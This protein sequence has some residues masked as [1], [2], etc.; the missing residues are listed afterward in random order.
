M[1]TRLSSEDVEA[2]FI[3]NQYP[4]FFQD[5]QAEISERRHTSSLFFDKGEYS[6]IYFKGVHIGYGHFALRQRTLIQF[7]TDFETIEMHFSLSGKTTVRTVNENRLFEFGDNQHNIIYVSPF[8]GQAEWAASSAMQIFEVNLLPEF[9]APYMPGGSQRFLDFERKIRHHEPSYLSPCNGRITPQMRWI[10]HEIIH[11]NRT[12][13]FKKMFIESKVI[14]LLLLQLE[15]INDAKRENCHKLKKSDVDK[16]HAVKDLLMGN[17]DCTSS[18]VQLAHQ[19]GTNE[20]TLKKGFK[21]V[22]GTTVFGFWNEMK[23]EHAKKLLLE[24]GLAISDVSE[25]VGYK[26]PQHF[27]AA[28]KR[29]FGVAPKQLKQ[30]T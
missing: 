21:E 23:M 10:I 2:L 26:N 14:E 16:M 19:V 30:K 17:L 3:E 5:E 12:G 11:C 18:L 13:I 9:F 29:K 6:E 20:C 24:E 25:R 28:F 4:A 15:Q 8:K 22:F 27:S 1:R 7:E